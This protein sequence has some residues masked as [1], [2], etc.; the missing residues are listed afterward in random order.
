KIVGCG[1][2]ARM[3]GFNG[4]SSIVIGTGMIPRG[5]MALITA[6]IGF[7][8]HIL[9]DDY[10]STIIFTISLVTLIAP[11]FLKAALRGAPAR[12]DAAEAGSA[13]A[14]TVIETESEAADIIDAQAANAG[15]VETTAT[16]EA[17]ATAGATATVA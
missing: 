4:R 14:E 6:Q 13:K 15:A 16:A 7:S 17:I 12:D 2:G 10:Y 9:S 5:E 11:L 3:A 8:Q 1:L